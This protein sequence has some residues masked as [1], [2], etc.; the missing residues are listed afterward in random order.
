MSLSATYTRNVTMSRQE[1]AVIQGKFLDR[2]EKEIVLLRGKVSVKRS[3]KAGGSERSVTCD[4]IA[5][6]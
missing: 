3:V 6:V 2:Q 4:V 5:P 1:A